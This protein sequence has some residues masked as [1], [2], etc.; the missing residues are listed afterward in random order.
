[1][2]PPSTVSPSAPSSKSA[3]KEVELPD[4]PWASLGSLDL[5]KP[6]TNTDEECLEDREIEFVLIN[7]AVGFK[8][9]GLN[10]FWSFCLGAAGFLDIAACLLPPF[11][12][13]F[14]HPDFDE[15]A[16]EPYPG[17]DAF[18]QVFLELT[19][20]LDHHDITIS[21]VFSGLFF[22]DGFLAAQAQRT[23]ILIK[24]E[25]REYSLS[26]RYGKT[27]KDPPKW[28]KTAS[29]VYYMTIAIQIL[30]LPVGFYF[31]I[32]LAFEKMSEGRAIEDIND[33]HE[34][35]T[36]AVAD[37]DDEIQHETFSATSKTSLIFAILH[38]LLLALSGTT[39]RAIKARIGSLIKALRSRA[40]KTVLGRAF[41]NPFKFR[42]TTKKLL[43]TVRWIKYLGP[44][45]KP[46]SKLKANVEDM[47]KKHR[48]RRIAEKQ[49]RVR[50]LLWGKKPVH[51]RGED[52]ARI[53]QSTYRAYWARKA[54]SS[55]IALR[56][57]G[58]YFCALKVQRAFRRRRETGRAKL[59]KKRDEVERLHTMR[60]KNADNLSHDEKKHFYELQGEL[61]EE[62]TKLL[63]RKLLMR[64]NTKFSVT[65]KMIFIVCVTMEIIQLASKPCLNN[66]KDKKSDRPMTMEEFV[67]ESLVPTR[68][69]DLPQCQLKKETKAE[70][71]LTRI[72]KRRRAESENNDSTKEVDLPWY[73]DEPVSTVQEAYSDIVGL[74]IIPA[75]V[76]E[77]P[78]CQEKK[79]K[80]HGWR[81]RQ[82]E[83][84]RRW[85]CKKPYSSSHAIYRL[86]VD[87]LLEEFLIVV[88]I[89]CFM[90]VFVTFF[91]GEFHP[92]T[93]ELVPKTFLTRWIL[94]GLLSQLMTN[95]QLATVTD[96]VGASW[97]EIVKLGPVRVLRW[98]AATLFPVVYYLWCNFI[99]YVWIPLVHYE[100]EFET[101]V[102]S[103]L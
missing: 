2:P 61:A 57:G 5:G 69:S 71:A 72:F 79:E 23:Q 6:I 15:V 78:E 48:Q 53:I 26:T 67:A 95:P 35:Y 55:L 83:D 7:D 33:M 90:D 97:K 94:P 9:E 56:E 58:K 101:M 88:G 98:S 76:A 34:T 100:N 70:R 68:A 47:I 17:I 27:T 41:R 59:R 77:W 44:L 89:V 20:F 22:I 31:V 66:Y 64:P 38:H 13:S 29:F 50:Q 14:T 84:S 82:E 51:M 30:L 25:E 75:P 65:W 1:M 28:W 73:C 8:F 54:T 92:T 19:R 85:Y 24:E 80:K 46:T 103:L 21:F 91:T 42:R 52:A 60:K 96:T 86:I 32:F 45:I 102:T 63:N 81:H 99:A 16:V 87:F 18:P 37:Q 74:V 62:A 39:S 49:K 40:I 11:V 12:L 10:Y 4:G 3:R 43:T 36:V 93:G